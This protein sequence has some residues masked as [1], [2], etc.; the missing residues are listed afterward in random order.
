MK[1]IVAIFFLHLWFFVFFGMIGWTL[2]GDMAERTYRQRMNSNFKWFLMPGIFSNLKFWTIS[3]KCMA[4]IIIPVV[5]FAY[6]KGMIAL[7][8][9]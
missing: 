7:L 1:Q 4:V 5:L 2:F 8:R 3:Q 6:Y 9:K